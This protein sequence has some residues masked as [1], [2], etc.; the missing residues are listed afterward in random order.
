[1]SPCGVR[2]G[3]DAWRRAKQ[4]PKKR[5]ALPREVV[6]GSVRFF[7]LLVPIIYCASGIAKARGDWLHQPYVLWTHLHSSYQTSVTLFLA[8]VLPPFAWTLFQVM[9]LVL[10][11]FAPLWFGWSRTRPYALLAAVSMHAMIGLMFGPVRYFAMLMATLLVASHLSERRVEQ[12][13]DW[14]AERTRS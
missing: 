11:S 1:L 6:S 13:T 14:L 9:T 10:E 8:N 5:K 7:Q 2:F 12:L 4:S 3:I